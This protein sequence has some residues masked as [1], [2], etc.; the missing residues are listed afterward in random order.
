MAL[1]GG[2]DFDVGGAVVAAG[3][4]ISAAAGAACVRGNG[5]GALSAKRRT[6]MISTT[7]SRGAAGVDLGGAAD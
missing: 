7:G 6:G 3:R 1:A 2:V 5:P 4:G